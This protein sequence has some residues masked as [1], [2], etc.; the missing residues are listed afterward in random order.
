MMTPPEVEIRASAAPWWRAVLLSIRKASSPT[1]VLD[2]NGP[3]E[4][5]K[6]VEDGAE[7][8]VTCT[9]PNNFAQTLM[10]DLWN[11]GFRPTEGAG[12]A[13]AMAAVKEHLKD[14]KTLLW[15]KEKIDQ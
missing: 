10:D 14:L 9:I 13:G 11:C 1:F 8:P 6:P 2:L 4:L 12:S 3:G 7:I 5:W 15:H